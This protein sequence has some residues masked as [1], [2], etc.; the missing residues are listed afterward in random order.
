[1]NLKT[2]IFL[3]EDKHLPTL[4]MDMVLVEATRELLFTCKSDDDNLYICACHCANA[5]KCEWLIAQTNPD[6][7]IDLLSNGMPIRDIFCQEE[8]LFVV[9][10][11]AGEKVK[12]VKS[13]LLSEVPD[14]ILPTADY[15]MDAE[16][17]EFEEEIEELRFRITNPVETVYT[18]S[19]F[20]YSTRR[21][22]IVFTLP[23]ID[24]AKTNGV[25]RKTHK[26]QLSQLLVEV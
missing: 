22:P 15:Y 5:E 19:P 25:I 13:L 3:T 8:R 2:R 10:L 9:T 14:H 6:T 16:E 11:H 26:Y 7:V 4:Y 12:T 1:M 24:T 18:E 23:Y 21:F 20:S 17:G